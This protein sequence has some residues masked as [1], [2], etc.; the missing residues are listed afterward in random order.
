MVNDAV[1][2]NI[3]IYGEGNLDTIAD[4]QWQVGGEWRAF[5]SQSTT[6]IGIQGG[7]MIGT[8]TIEQVLVPTKSGAFT[9]PSVQFSYF[10]PGTGTYQS[11]NTEPINISVEPNGQ[12]VASVVS[13]SDARANV[14]EVGAGTIR[15][16][17]LAPESGTITPLLTQKRGYWLLW[18]LPLFLLIG[19]YGL[20]KRKQ[21]MLKDPEGIR[22]RKASRKAYRALQRVD[23]NSNEYYQAV[24]R[25]LT[26]YISDKLN[27]SVSGLTQ[28]QLSSLLR[29]HGVQAELVEG[30][31]TCLTISE[32]G[33]YAPTSQFDNG[34]FHQ[35][36]KSLVAGLEKAFKQG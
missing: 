16:I 13:T 15:P 18:A 17:K 10:D 12:E 9:I 25:I 6:D 32:M 21:K 19:Q 1:T 22:S 8:R 33:Q 26:T 30:V 23:K 28:V 3:A 24:G 2:L 27:Q 11:T 14:V 29:D 7:N 35:E 4:P 36:V 5:D 20:Q 31:E 34:N